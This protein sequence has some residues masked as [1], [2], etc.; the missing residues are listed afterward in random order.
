ME[1]INPGPGPCNYYII[2]EEETKRAVQLPSERNFC[3]SS[4]RRRISV[5]KKAT[6][7]LLLCL[8]NYALCYEDIWGSGSIAPPFLTKH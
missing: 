7:K 4:R 3:Y 2:T 8:T 1:I 5:K 6:A